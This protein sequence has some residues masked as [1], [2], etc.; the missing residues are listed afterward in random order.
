MKFLLTNEV[1]ELFSS[2]F[3]PP[4]VT[5]F[6]V[7]SQSFPISIALITPQIVYFR[8]NLELIFLLFL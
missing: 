8:L 2:P 4:P 1:G 5:V 7:L 3:V 6:E